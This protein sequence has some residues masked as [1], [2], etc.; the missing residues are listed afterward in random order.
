VIAQFW[1]RDGGG[2]YFTPDHHEPLIARTND[3]RDNATPSGNS[4]QLMNLLRLAAL[5]GD[6]ELRALA[7]RTMSTF[8][9]DV[10]RSPWSSERFLAGVDFARGGPVEIAI[11]GDPSQPETQALLKQVYQTYLPN[12]VLMLHDPARPADTVASPL[13]E[14]R[15]L[16]AGQPAAY[17][18]RNSTCRPPVTTPADLAEQLAR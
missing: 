16:V 12:R 17:V 9:G 18:C 7:D 10:T 11:V 6:G 15:T 3:V 1:D 14:G 2:F 13:L 4:V 5:L 8:A